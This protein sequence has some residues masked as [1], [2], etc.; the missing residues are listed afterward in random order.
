MTRRKRKLNFFRLI[1]VIVIIAALIACGFFGARYLMNKFANVDKPNNN[2]SEKTEI[3]TSNNEET[4]IE[5]VDYIVYEDKDNE[6]G[7]DFILADLKFTCVK[8]LISYDLNNLTSSEHIKLGSIQEYEDKIASIG[9]D[10]DKLNYTKK[11]KSDIANS[12]TCKIL[13]PVINTNRSELD[14]YNGEKLHFDLL[15]NLSTVETLKPYNEN[16]ETVVSS[17]NFNLLVYDSYLSDFIYV[18]GER[19]RKPDSIHVYTFE[20]VVQEMNKSGL[21]VESAIFVPAGTTQTLEANDDWD[22]ESVKNI[23]DKDLK[24]GDKY[25]LFFSNQKDELDSF[26]GKL[27]IEFSDGERIEL[28]TNK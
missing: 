4:K 2:P 16:K 3:E 1:L 12:I 6:L 13:I 20:I 18:N 24:T 5:V 28:S 27:I 23:F 10:L 21:H 26:K 9:I 17:D 11:I 7:F 8:D 19:V 15:T 25:A 14:V 22:S